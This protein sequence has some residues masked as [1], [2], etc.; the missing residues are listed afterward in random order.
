MTSI[1]Y[2]TG[3]WVVKVGVCEVDLYG[4][5]SMPN[6]SKIQR[7]RCQNGRLNLIDLTLWHGMT[8]LQTLQPESR[9]SL[10][11]QIWIRLWRFLSR[12][13]SAVTP[14]GNV[15][16]ADAFCPVQ[17]EHGSLHERHEGSGTA[18]WTMPGASNSTRTGWP[19]P[20]IFGDSL[21]P[22]GCFPRLRGA[23]TAAHN[24]PQRN[25]VGRVNWVIWVCCGLSMENYKRH[26]L[27]PSRKMIDNK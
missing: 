7:G 20:T 24:A 1:S 17:A 14:S 21:P 26:I 23:G 22:A 2:L 3:H 5:T 19:T 25:R 12:F 15:M 8:Q 27:K 11:R 18:I 4:V 16:P 10:F 6:L 9:P 13:W